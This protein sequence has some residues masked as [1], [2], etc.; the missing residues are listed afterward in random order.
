MEYYY[1]IAFALLS[2]FVHWYVTREKETFELDDTPIEP[3]CKDMTPTKL[4]N[5]FDNDMDVITE[6]FLK[7]DIPISAIK[8]PKYY[9]HIAS[10]LYKY[11]VLTCKD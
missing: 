2:L 8:K 1:L 4:F 11:N 9:P 7:Y 6:V 3:L 5:I 10:I